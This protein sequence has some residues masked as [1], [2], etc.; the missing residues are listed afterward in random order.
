MSS[1]KLLFTKHYRCVVSLDNVIIS[2]AQCVGFII[3]EI[4]FFCR[5][6]KSTISKDENSLMSEYLLFKNIGTGY[7]KFGIAFIKQNDGTGLLIYVVFLCIK[8]ILINSSRNRTDIILPDY[9]N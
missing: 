7:G 4:N 8:I 2:F 3:I 5:R 1:I 9:L 6:L